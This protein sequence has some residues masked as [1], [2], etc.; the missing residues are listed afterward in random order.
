MAV[1][2][3]SRLRGIFLSSDSQITA[4]SE[5]G[6]DGIVEISRPETDPGR[7][8][9]IFEEDVADPADLIAQDFCQQSKNSS[10]VVTGRGGLPPNPN[11]YLDSNNVRV[12]WVD[13][14]PRTA[15][16]D[17]PLSSTPST[18]DRPGA[19]VPA[20]G[21]VMLPDGRVQLVAYQTPNTSS[22]DDLP[23][24]RRCATMN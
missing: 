15:T 11:Q 12:S 20:R 1:R 13:P 5:L 24:S 7:G 4:S 14:V 16:S 9:I 2:S 22:R 21:W 6:I 8:L 3:R 17:R 18:P 23:K 10:F 19:I